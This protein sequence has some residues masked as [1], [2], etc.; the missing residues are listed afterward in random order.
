MVSSWR[1]IGYVNPRGQ[2]N[3]G[4]LERGGR[5]PWYRLH[6]ITCGTTYAAWQYVENR[7][8]PV[9]QGG[10]KGPRKHEAEWPDSR[11]DR[12]RQA[13]E[14][15]VERMQGLVAGQDRLVRQLAKLVDEYRGW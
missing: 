8:C 10:P 6:C 5:G 13:I 7:R 3:L 11:E 14:I 9:C 12:R 1:T 4:Q 15:L 2:I